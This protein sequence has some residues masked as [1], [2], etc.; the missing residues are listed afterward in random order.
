MQINQPVHAVVEG[1]I[2]DAVV[3]KLFAETGIQWGT[4]YRQDGRNQLIKKLPA[5]NQSA[6]FC[7]WL[8]LCDLDQ[9]HCGP[10]L[11]HDMI[12]AF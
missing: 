12:R 2:D 7:L 8:A 11:H 1:I 5:Y 3:R 9:N 4:I 10:S 6:R